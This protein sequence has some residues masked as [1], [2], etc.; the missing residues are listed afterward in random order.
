[1]VDHKV[2]PAKSVPPP[3]TTKYVRT[4]PSALHWHWFLP[5]GRDSKQGNPVEWDPVGKIN[6]FAYKDIFVGIIFKKVSRF[7]FI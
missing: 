1:M 7:W 3:S 5:M 4:V 6:I 2:K